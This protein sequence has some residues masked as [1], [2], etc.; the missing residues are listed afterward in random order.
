LPL[1]CADV[2]R[3]L[4]SVV[5]GCHRLSSFFDIPRTWHGLAPR[6]VRAPQGRCSSWRRS[7]ASRQSHWAVSATV[8]ANC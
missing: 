5:I 1:T 8:I 4:S 7:R 2:C 6:V 3:W